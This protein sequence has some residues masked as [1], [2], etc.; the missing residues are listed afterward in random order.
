MAQYLLAIRYGDGEPSGEEFGRSGGARCSMALSTSTTRRSQ[1][2]SPET[3]QVFVI[4][5]LWV[6]TAPL[7]TAVF[8]PLFPYR[9]H[10]ARWRAAAIRGQ[11]RGLGRS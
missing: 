10:A 2:P 3:P 5:G 1:W 8:E 7:Q 6:V 4:R 9:G 11:V